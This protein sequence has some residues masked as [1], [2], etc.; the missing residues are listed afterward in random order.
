MSISCLKS[1]RFGICRSCVKSHFL[2]AL[3]NRTGQVFRER[4]QAPVWVA[5][6]YR[7]MPPIAAFLT[8]VEEATGEI[9]MLTIR[10]HRFPF[11]QNRQLEPV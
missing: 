11:C 10:E 6:E 5:M 9:E 2:P 7:Y 8:D 4:Y 3:S 1:Q